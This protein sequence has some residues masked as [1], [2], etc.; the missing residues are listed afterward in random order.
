MA[1]NVSKGAGN[2]AK[3]TVIGV[4]IAGTVGTG[5]VSIVGPS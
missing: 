4:A 5:I 1:G 2:V 3:G